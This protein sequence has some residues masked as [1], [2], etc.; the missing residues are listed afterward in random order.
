[1]ANYNAFSV[2][3]APAYTSPNPNYDEKHYI[4]AFSPLLNAAGFPAQFIVDQGRSG[5]QPTGRSYPIPPCRMCTGA[6]QCVAILLCRLGAAEMS[7][8]RGADS[9][10]G[11]CA[12]RCP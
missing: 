4:E 1:V 3:S 12:R 6:K 10:G 7:R 8:V 11:S 9:G 5:K 2:A